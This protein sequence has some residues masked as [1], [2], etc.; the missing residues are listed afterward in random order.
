MSVWVHDCGRPLTDE[1]DTGHGMVCW[2][3]IHAEESEAEDALVDVEDP[4]T[5]A[6]NDAFAVEPE[7]DTR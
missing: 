4:I 3:C 2:P 7:G 1:R 5:A 6:V